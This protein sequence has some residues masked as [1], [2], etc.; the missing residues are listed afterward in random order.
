MFGLALQRERKRCQVDLLLATE[1]TDLSRCSFRESD[2]HAL[3]FV[4]CMTGCHSRMHSPMDRAATWEAV[5]GVMKAEVGWS[6]NLIRLSAEDWFSIGSDGRVTA[7]FDEAAGFIRV[8]DFSLT[9]FIILTAK[10]KPAGTDGSVVYVKA[11][12]RVF[13]FVYARLEDREAKIVE[14]IERAI[15]DTMASETGATPENLTPSTD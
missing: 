5:E 7:E 1:L 4:A 12:E 15:E 14:R 10:V 9:R 3:V 11:E 2:Q 8:P 13:P 6:T